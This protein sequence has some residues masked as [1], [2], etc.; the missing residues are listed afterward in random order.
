MHA[1][2][3]VAAAARET[4]DADAWVAVDVAFTEL[5]ACWNCG[6]ADTRPDRDSKAAEAA[7]NEGNNI[8]ILLKFV[9]LRERNPAVVV[10]YVSWQNTE[11]A[12]KR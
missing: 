9:M 1:V 4:V 6:D 8:L 3:P 11:T 12:T 10:L 5:E 2:V 7:H